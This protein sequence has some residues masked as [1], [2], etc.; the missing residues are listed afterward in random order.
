MSKKSLLEV[1]LVL[2][3]LKEVIIGEDL[4]NCEIETQLD[5]LSVKS[6]KK[7][8]L[9]ITRTFVTLSCLCITL[10]LSLLS[11]DRPNLHEVENGHQSFLVFLPLVQTHSFFLSCKSEKCT[12]ELLV[13]NCGLCTLSLCMG[14]YVKVGADAESASDFRVLGF[15]SLCFSSHIRVANKELVLWEKWAMEIRHIVRG[16]KSRKKNAD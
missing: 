5:H 4:I 13:S 11:K 9:Y 16:Q 15:S 10:Y 7:Q 1:Y 12:Q 8:E 2:Q 14:S 3:Q 6:K